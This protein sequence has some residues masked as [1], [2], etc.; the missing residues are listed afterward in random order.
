MSRTGI[1]FRVTHAVARDMGRS[2]APHVPDKLVT[3]DPA[4]LY[5]D[6]VDVVVEVIGGTTVAKDIVL[7]AAAAGKDVVTANKAL[8]AEC[9]PE[10]YA[11][12][13]TA[14]VGIA[15]EAS[16]AGGLPIIGAI[17]RGLIA[18]RIDVVEG[19][20]NTTC[21][22]IL[23]KMLDARQSY[24]QA[25]ADAQR[26]GYAEADPTL[27]V[28]GSDTAHKL[29]ILASL[30]F[31]AHIDFASIPVEGIQRI[32]LLD[33]QAGREL[34][35]ACKLLGVGRS[36]G[37]APA[38]RVQP[39]FLPAEHP[40][41]VVNGKGSGVSLCGHASGPMMMAGTGAGGP[42][43]AS[44]VVSDIVETALGNARRTFQQLPVFDTA[45]CK[46]VSAVAA[47]ADAGVYLRFTTADRD[48]AV[49]KIAD[50]C[51]AQGV[52][53]ASGPLV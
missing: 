51:R 33:L 48:V 19:I 30:V 42:A 17:Q 37:A 10:V 39:M 32:S 47:S 52:E 20:L 21:N 49:S 46:R 31:G 28:D 5:G 4:V 18:N 43:T 24:D 29:A 12:A 40:L 6:D 9:G 7:S 2:R 44:A 13:R 1:D 27:D 50:V 11:A 45:G 41:A 14:G 16:V 25:L 35:L 8:L 36:G 15:F 38:L 34:G 26:L 22:F 53:D 23:T 3:D